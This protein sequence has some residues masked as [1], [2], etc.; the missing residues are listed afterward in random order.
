MN[1]RSDDR[2]ARRELLDLVNKGLLERIGAG[3][4]TKYQ[5]A[6]PDKEI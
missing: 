3:A 1:N 6:N 5:L 2:K 4:G